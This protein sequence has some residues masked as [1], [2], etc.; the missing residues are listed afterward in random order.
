MCSFTVSLF[1]LL[2]FIFNIFGFS[3]L[4]EIEWVAEERVTLFTTDGLVQI[5]G[6][7]VPRR[8]TSSNVC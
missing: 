2:G 8:V 4:T 1:D 6:S 3:C 5:G 7:M